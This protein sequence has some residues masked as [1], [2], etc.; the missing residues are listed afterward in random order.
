MSFKSVSKILRAAALLIF[1][2]VKSTMET[3]DK[4]V[5]SVISQRHQNDASVFIVNFKQISQTVLMFPS[6]TLDK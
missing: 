4:C 6:L 3:P 1:S 5:K 2:G